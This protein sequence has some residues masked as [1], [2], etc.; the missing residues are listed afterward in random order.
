MRIH[1]KKRSNKKPEVKNLKIH[2]HTRLNGWASSTVPEIRL[3]GNW[4]EKL[5][6]LP[7]Q[8]V[9]ITTMNKLLI[10]RVDE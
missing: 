7:E 3:C 5:S 6:F 9:N 10:I 8:R 4:L 1:E 2:P